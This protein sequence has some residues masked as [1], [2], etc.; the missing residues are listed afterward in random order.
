ML[1]E[2]NA[3]SA[4]LLTNM[5]PY[6]HFLDGPGRHTE[7][8]EI[9]DQMGFHFRFYAILRTAPCHIPKLSAVGLT[10]VYPTLT[11]S[12][13]KRCSPAPVGESLKWM[14]LSFVNMHRTMR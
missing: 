9:A 5:R 3:P 10:S 7:R 4:N 14:A 6:E 8:V 12:S 13:K 11:V 2:L 1:G